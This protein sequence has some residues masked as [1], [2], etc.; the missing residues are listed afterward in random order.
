M[1]DGTARFKDKDGKEFFHF[2]ECST[3]SEDTVV[4]EI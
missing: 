3:M 2:M 1:P 4:A